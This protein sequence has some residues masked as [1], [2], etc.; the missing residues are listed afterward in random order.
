MALVTGG[1]PKSGG[2]FYDAAWDRV[3]APPQNTT[4]NGLAGGTCTPG[5]NNG[6]Q[7]EYEEGDEINQLLLNG[8]GPF[9]SVI[10]GGVLSLDS[11]RFVRDPFSK[12]VPLCSRLSLELHPHQHDLRR[13][14]RS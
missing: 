7:T 5:K 12:P 10:D 4:G 1:T 3:L 2:V 9:Q 14:S 13:D 11:I 8:G 6:S